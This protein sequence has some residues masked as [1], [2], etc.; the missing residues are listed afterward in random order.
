MDSSI[1]I[2]TPPSRAEKN[3]R[4]TT[5]SLCSHHSIDVVNELRSGLIEHTPHDLEKSLRREKSNAPMSNR[6]ATNRTR[7]ITSYSETLITYV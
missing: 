4:A 5:T 3:A 6:A 1:I 2:R 7:R